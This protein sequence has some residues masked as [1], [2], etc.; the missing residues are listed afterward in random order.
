MITEINA[1]LPVLCS[2][3]NLIQGAK[4]V[5][6]RTGR[7]YK[8]GHCRTQAGAERLVNLDSSNRQ[9]RRGEADELANTCPAL[10]FL[11]LSLHPS[12]RLGL[13]TD[14]CRLP[15]TQCSKESTTKL[16]RRSWGAKG[17]TT[18]ECS[19]KTAGTDPIT[20]RALASWG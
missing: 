7:I 4:L 9:A 14:E 6:L 1:R 17:A 13:F 5:W 19:H 11:P 10:S 20:V 16:A 15:L 8:S 12:D 2:D 3:H 18:R